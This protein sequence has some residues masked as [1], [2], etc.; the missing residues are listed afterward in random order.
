MN[1]SIY[2]RIDPAALQWQA[3]NSIRN[4]QQIRPTERIRESNQDDYISRP[5]NQSQR[6]LSPQGSKR[7][8]AALATLRQIQDLV[9]NAKE[10]LADPKSITKYKGAERLLGSVKETVSDLV[11]HASSDGTP[12]FGE[13]FGQQRNGQIGAYVK[14]N[15][16]YITSQNTENQPDLQSALTFASTHL[17]GQN[18]IV[19]QLEAAATNPESAA[20][21]LERM[22]K[23]VMAISD[24]LTQ[25]LNPAQTDPMPLNGIDQ[26]AS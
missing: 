24:R 11:R 22:S 4:E 26:K 15:L 1:N 19:T 18:G 25:L 2:R 6:S 21:S 10:S 23:T 3:Q 8:T 12:V 13:T 9:D 5:V 16:A 20:R 14:N 7:A 17:V